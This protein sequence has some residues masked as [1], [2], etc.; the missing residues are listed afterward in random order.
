MVGSKQQILYIH[1]GD[2]FSDY[3]NFLSFLQNI[4]VRNLPG[5]ED[6]PFWSKTAWDKLTEEGYEVF[7]PTM[8]NK[9]NAKYE[10]W[11]IWFERYFEYLND[12]V[13]LIGW[14]LGGYFLAKYL[15]ENKTP[16]TIK[17]LFLIAPLF[18]N[19]DAENDGDDGGD[20]SFATENVRT[21]LDR[22]DK[23]CLFH[24]KDDPIVPIRHSEMF[25]EAVPEAEFITFEDKNHF[26]VEE[27]PE[28][29]SK[30]KALT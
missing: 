30:I 18:E 25:K 14:S 3:N 19:E 17:A 15:V 24:S 8:P 28:L 5:T 12:D 9:I 7:T 11:R 20:F 1:G 26:L 29:I 22:T 27:F 13:I 2:A 10:E 4:P 6:K 21:L 23:I 16:F